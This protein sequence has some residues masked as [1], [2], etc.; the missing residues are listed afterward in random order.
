MSGAPNRDAGSNG[1]RATGLVFSAD[2][3]SLLSC[4]DDA[5]VRLWDVATGKQ[6]LVINVGK[7]GPFLRASLSADG[8]FIATACD[9][10]VHLWDAATG[11][12]LPRP[13]F[14]G[15]SSFG[16]SVAFA[17]A[18]SL[19]AVHSQG[20]AFL[21]DAAA[22]KTLHVF[23]AGGKGRTDFAFSPDGK[24]VAAFDEGWEMS[25]WD[26]A[27]GQPRFAPSSNPRPERILAAAASPDRRWV[28]TGSFGGPVTFGDVRTGQALP[29]PAPGPNDLYTPFNRGA[30][31]VGLRYSSDGRTL[32]VRSQI[33]VQA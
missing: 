18:G 17:P 5:T 26:V 13:R 2:G 12:R 21:W 11:A 33:D 16:D 4:G 24:T 8:R 20:S 14:D 9:G 15:G 3:K 29:I 28:V 30:T 10:S 7:G 27:S 23:T 1:E 32:Y 31:I 22:G 6:R 25:L 19:L